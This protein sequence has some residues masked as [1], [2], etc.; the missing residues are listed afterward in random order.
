MSAVTPFAGA[1]K[2]SELLPCSEDLACSDLDGVELLI[3]PTGTL[4]LTA[5]S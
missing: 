5:V 3:A 4:P 2:C 1:V